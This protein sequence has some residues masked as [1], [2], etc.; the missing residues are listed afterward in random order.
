MSDR[1]RE[2]GRRVAQDLVLERDLEAILKYR[3]AGH[4]RPL[5]IQDLCEEIVE[6][7]AADPESVVDVVSE[8]VG[9]RAFDV[10]PTAAES[11]LESDRRDLWSQWHRQAARSDGGPQSTQERL[12]DVEAD[13]EGPGGPP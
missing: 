11:G 3:L 1:A 9:E 10:A 2:I 13:A 4:L 5:E 12:A 6:L 8:A 7:G